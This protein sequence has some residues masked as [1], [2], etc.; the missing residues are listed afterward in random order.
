MRLLILALILSGCATQAK[1]EQKLNTWIGYKSKALIDN[2]GIPTK[3]MNL[4][5]GRKAFEYAYDPGT[6]QHLVFNPYVGYQ[7]Y[8]THNWCKTTFIINEADAIEKW[9][10]HGTSCRAN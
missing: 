8:N 3:T 6:Q 2:W 5:N 1:Y 10:L 9:M 4:E 7:M